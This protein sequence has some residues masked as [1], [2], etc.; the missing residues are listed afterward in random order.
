MQAESEYFQIQQNYLTLRQAND[1]LNNEIFALRRSKE[2]II[3]ELKRL[4]L[5]NSQF[6]AAQNEIRSVLQ[7]KYNRQPL[8]QK[9]VELPA[10]DEARHAVERYKHNLEQIGMVNMAVKEEYD[11]EYTRWKFL[12]DQRNDLVASE[13]GLT[14][15]IS[16]I[17]QIAR[18]QYL[19]IFGKIRNNFKS[20]FT[21]FSEAVKPNCV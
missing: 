2:Q 19:E 10:E 1:K 18:D 13:Q 14:E 17:D 20:T 15:V 8:E 5:A 21:V 12:N 3:D 16:Q 9:P 4:E 7:E 6:T 11:Q